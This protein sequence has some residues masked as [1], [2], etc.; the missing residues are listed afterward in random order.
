MISARIFSSYNHLASLVLHVL[1]GQLNE[2]E[3]VNK[4]N[5]TAEIIEEV[6]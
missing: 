5:L 3:K 1:E 4:A 2:F 6:I